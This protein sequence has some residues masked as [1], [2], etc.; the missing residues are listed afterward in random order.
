M[1]SDSEGHWWAFAISK[2][3]LIILERKSVPD[4]LKEMES[5]ECAVTLESLMMDM[6][7]GEARSLCRL[8]LRHV[9]GSH[10]SFPFN[11]TCFNVSRFRLGI[12]IAHCGP[13]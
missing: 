12:T 8:L 9:P 13:Q 11:T 7:L 1:T 10:Y 2:T 5:L 6:H 4:H 3:S